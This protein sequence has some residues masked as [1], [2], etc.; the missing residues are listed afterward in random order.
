M[1]H[2]ARLE[3]YL[4]RRR[5]LDIA[6]MLES[7]PERRFIALRSIAEGADP[8]VQAQLERRLTTKPPRVRQTKQKKPSSPTRQNPGESTPYRDKVRDD[9]ST[10]LAS[11]GLRSRIRHVS[12]DSVYTVVAIDNDRVIASTDE[13]VV[14]IGTRTAKEWNHVA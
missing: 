8:E 10:V 9:V 13:E 6:A 11:F 5:M 14:V 3:D 2:R 7:D 4:R 12:D 1:N